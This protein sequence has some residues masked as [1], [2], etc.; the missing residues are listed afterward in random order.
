ML[1]HQILATLGHRCHAADVETKEEGKIKNAKV[2][3]GCT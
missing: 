1:A 2:K 3:F